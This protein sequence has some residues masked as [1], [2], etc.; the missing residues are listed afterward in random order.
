[1]YM[2]QKPEVGPHS[3]SKFSVCLYWVLS[4]LL[5]GLHLSSQRWPSCRPNGGWNNWQQS[6][7]CR[8]MQCT[9]Y[10]TQGHYSVHCTGLKSTAVYSVHCTLYTVQYCRV[11]CTGLQSTWFGCSAWCLWHCTVVIYW[12]WCH[13]ID[14]FKFTETGVVYWH[15]CHVLPPFETTGIVFINQHCCN[16]PTQFHLVPLSCNKLILLLFTDTDGGFW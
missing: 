9:V 8:V 7:D 15:Y 14:L 6:H 16:F 12:P 5:F 4:K 1:M 11:Q 10:R 13:L 2:L 3:G